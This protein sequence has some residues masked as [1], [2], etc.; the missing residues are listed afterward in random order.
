MPQLDFA[1]FPAQLVWLLISFVILY[2]VLS[3]VG[4]PQVDRALAARRDRIEGDLEKA[5]QMK[6]ETEAVIA[7]YEKALSEARASAQQT[8]KETTDRL[9]AEAAERQRAATLK[10]DKET[11]AAEARIADAKTAALANLR[12]VA[13]EVAQSA[14]QKLTGSSV[15]EARVGAA[16]DAVLKERA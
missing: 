4:L 11:E 8:L 2:V 14:A 3:K 1:T 16:V 6:A 12:T 5:Q 7:A 13:V 15:D 9:N 10:L